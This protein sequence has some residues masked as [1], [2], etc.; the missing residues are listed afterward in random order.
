MVFPRSFFHYF[1]HTQP[2]LYRA[3]ET[4]TKR[5][6]LPL[7]VIFSV[8]VGKFA[9]QLNSFPNSPF[10]NHRS[11]VQRTAASRRMMGPQRKRGLYAQPNR[12]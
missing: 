4:Y 1:P 2:A 3:I 7:F 12:V 10:H 8:Q 11:F 5:R 9:T 6:L